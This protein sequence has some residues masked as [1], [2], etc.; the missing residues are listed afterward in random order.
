MRLRPLWKVVVVSPNTYTAALTGLGDV[1]MLATISAAPLEALCK[2][3]RG[4]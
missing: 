1:E 4:V 2:P 3:D